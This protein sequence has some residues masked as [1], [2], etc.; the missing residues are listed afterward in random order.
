MADNGR[1]YVATSTSNR[2]PYISSYPQLYCPHRV[3][4]N[5]TFAANITYCSLHCIKKQ[6][7]AKKVTM[8]I[9]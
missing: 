2:I 9:N 7:L 8:V 3:T 5:D 6:K 1:V 4:G